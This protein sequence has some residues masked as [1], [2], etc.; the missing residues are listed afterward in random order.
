MER[1]PRVELSEAEAGLD[2]I[3]MI[4]KFKYKYGNRKFWARG[5]YC[6]ILGH[7]EKCVREYIQNPLVEDKLADQLSM[8]E[9]TLCT[10]LVSI[11]LQAKL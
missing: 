3:H 2:H 7:N 4:C 9:F 5:Y 6:V 10:P 8:K 11:H 1:K